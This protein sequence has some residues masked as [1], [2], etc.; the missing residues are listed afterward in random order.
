MTE[1]RKTVTTETT[2]GAP[3]STTQTLEKGVPHGDE[4]AGGA[5]GGAVGGAVV[6]AVAGGPIGAVVGGA[7]GAAT[8]ATVGALDDKRKDEEVVI[9]KEEKT[10]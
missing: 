8:G 9:T 3:A 10:W 1:E 5:M 2:S 4:E 7:I 6:G